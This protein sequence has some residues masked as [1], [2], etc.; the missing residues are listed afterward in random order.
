[1]WRS[2][3]VYPVGV[4]INGASVKW[5]RYLSCGAGEL[6]ASQGGSAVVKV[7]III[8]TP[9]GSHE[10]IQ[11]TVSAR[12]A[13][14][15]VRGW[16]QTHSAALPHRRLWSTKQIPHLHR[17][18][19]GGHLLLHCSGVKNLQPIS[20]EK[21][22]LFKPFLLLF[23]TWPAQHENINIICFFLKWQL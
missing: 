20:G 21:L 18:K 17:R 23:Y 4:C 9:V 14:W 7:S 22:T 11:E 15:G 13:G 10:V 3:Y 5:L 12:A 6:G 1:M 16:I 2:V 8:F 19:E